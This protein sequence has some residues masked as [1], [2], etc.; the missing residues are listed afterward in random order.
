MR[1]LL[2]P[3]ALYHG[4]NGALMLAAPEL[5]YSIV[6]DVGHTGPLNAHFVRDIGLAFIAAAAGLV[7][8]ALNFKNSIALWPAAIFLAGHAGLHMAELGV[9][10][11]P[12]LAG[13]RD[14]AT[15]VVPGLL[16]LFLLT[17]PWKKEV[18]S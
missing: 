3:L 17:F 15:I 12:P 5:W 2:T 1:F 11:A 4:A 18:R 8:A 14:L 6:P 10:G 13:A 16:P 9:H 7:I